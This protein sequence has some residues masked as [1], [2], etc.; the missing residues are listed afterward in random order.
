MTY[1]PLRMV[2]LGLFCLFVVLSVAP[3]SAQ[4]TAIGFRDI[5][6]NSGLAVALAEQLTG[7]A[8][9]DGVGVLFRIDNA[10]PKQSNIAGIYW[11]DDAGVLLSI[12]TITPSNG[13]SMDIGGSPDNVPGGAG[14]SPSFLADFW[15]R[16]VGSAA[17]GVSPEQWVNVAFSLQNTK[18]FQDVADALTSGFLRL[19][20]HVQSV[21]TGQE[22]SDSFVSTEIPEPSTLLLLGTG[23]VGLVLHKRRKQQS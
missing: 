5:E 14:I 10:G 12:L 6:N 3:Q 22:F 20:L 9:D 8:T 23:L 4:A 7:E 19:G 1:R 21:G 15:V 18:T 11:D 13:V 17:N 2:T 16:S